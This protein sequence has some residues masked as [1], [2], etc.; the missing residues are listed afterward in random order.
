MRLQQGFVSSRALAENIIGLISFANAWLVGKPE[1]FLPVPT[2]TVARYPGIWA[3]S[4]VL[5][6]ALP[7]FPKQITILRRPS[8]EGAQDSFLISY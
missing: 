5:L 7:A 3:Y 6:T 8:I 1:R 2:W 4:L